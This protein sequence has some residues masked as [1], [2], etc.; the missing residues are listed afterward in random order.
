MVLALYLAICLRIEGSA[1]L[2]L[3]IYSI[4]EARLVRTSKDTASI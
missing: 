2:L 1:K 3:C 4:A